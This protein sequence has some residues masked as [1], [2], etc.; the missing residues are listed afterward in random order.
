MVDLVG[1]AQGPRPCLPG[2]SEVTGAALDVAE[3]V[4]LVEPVGQLPPQAD[5]PLAASDGLGVLAEQA[6]Q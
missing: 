3:L 5:R 2:R 6:W 1:D 4:G